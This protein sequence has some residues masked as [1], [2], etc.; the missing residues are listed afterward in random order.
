MLQRAPPRAAVALLDFSASPSSSFVLGAP[1]PPPAEVGEA[2]AQAFARNSEGSWREA[3]PAPGPGEGGAISL[4]PSPGFIRSP[5]IVVPLWM[6]TGNAGWQG[7]VIPQGLPMA[8]N[9]GSASYGQT[10]LMGASA[11]E[12]RQV[13]LPLV[14]EAACRH[15]IPI[16]LLDALI[17][18]ESRYNPMAKS[19]VGAFG[20]GQL[21]PGTARELGVNRYDLRGNLD[22]AAR[23]LA[24]QLA[25]FGQPSL[26][27]AAYNAGPHRVRR[28]GRIPN[29]AETRAYVSAV[30]SNWSI[31]EAARVRQS[32]QGDQQRRAS[33]AWRSAAI[34][35]SSGG[36]SSP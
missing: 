5:K 9:C 28:L 32:G 12:R 24:A 3:S 10:G 25:D 33:A 8:G 2:M 4:T 34:V 20:L 22:G 27:L 1:T 23:Y 6:R 30:L 18:Q 17:M 16:G 29:I 35:I 7:S 14:V 13:Y 21:M 19:P 31:L 11:E 15:G 36:G 26:A